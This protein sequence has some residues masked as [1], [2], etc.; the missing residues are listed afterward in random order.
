MFVF[1]FG[2]LA[3]LCCALL[4]H[5]FAGGFAVGLLILVASYILARALA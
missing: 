4:I 1:L 3:V 5:G 2:V